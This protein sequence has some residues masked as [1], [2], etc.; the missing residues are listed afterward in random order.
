[1]I[2]DVGA[3]DDLEG[4]YLSLCLKAASEIHRYHFPKEVKLDPG[5]PITL[6]Q[7]LGVWL[8]FTPT[9]VDI[10]ELAKTG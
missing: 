7:C 9:H 5:T 10:L 6:K 2:W 1:V 4:H 3:S 8:H